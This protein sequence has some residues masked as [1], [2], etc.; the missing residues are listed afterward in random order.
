M[1]IPTH[2]EEEEEEEDLVLSATCECR[3]A[4]PP[5]LERQGVEKEFP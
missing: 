3:V 1:P 5:P 4:L 2:G